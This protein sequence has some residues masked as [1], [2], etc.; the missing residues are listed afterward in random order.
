MNYKDEI[1]KI[2]YKIEAKKI[3]KARLEER[4][5]SLTEERDKIL[6]QMKELK[7]NSIEALNKEI[8]QLDKELQDE[9]M[10]CSQILN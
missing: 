7:V 1:E 8:E 10:K 2:Q 4:A 9:I 6:V 3:E 5:K